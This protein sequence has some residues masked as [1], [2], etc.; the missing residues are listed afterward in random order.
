MENHEECGKPLPASE[1][2]KNAPPT[3]LKRALWIAA[4]FAV[5]GP[6]PW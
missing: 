6:R 1:S 4:L 2:K 5:V 3:R